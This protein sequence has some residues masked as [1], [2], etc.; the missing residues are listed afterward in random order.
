MTRVT[1][2][3]AA[4]AG[5]TAAAHPAQCAQRPQAVLLDMGGVLSDEAKAHAGA[6]RR[7][8]ARSFATGLRS[9]ARERAST[10]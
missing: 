9:G 5:G 1:T 6:R 8:R 2:I 7:R 10:D 4:L 3:E